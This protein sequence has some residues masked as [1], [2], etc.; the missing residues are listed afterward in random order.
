MAKKTRLANPLAL[1]VLALLF[2]RPMHPYEMAATMKERHKEDSIKLRYGSLY[3]VIDMLLARGLLAAK[4]VSR[5]GKRP[6]RTV[7]AL[8]PSGLDE[9]RD[10]MRELLRD[11]AKEY[12]Q[13]EAGLCLLPVLPP[14]EAVSL[15]RQRALQL[16]GTVWQ[17]EAQLAELA[18]QDL[19]ALTAGQDLPSPLAGKKFPPLFSVEGE[20]RLALVKAELAFV[21]ELVR[22][23]AE[24]GWGPVEMWRDLQA[25][26]A[27]QHEQANNSGEP[28]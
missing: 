8:T 19:S 25:A 5:E 15:L 7:Y 11:P 22:R 24:E 26:C 1:A 18:Q 6:E 16:S 9:L 10:W 14:D 17:M 2:E 28:Q 20:Y 23:I 21:N 4:E 13:F 12:P 3:T 27:R